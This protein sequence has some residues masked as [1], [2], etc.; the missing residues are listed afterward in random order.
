MFIRVQENQ[1]YLAINETDFHELVEVL[2][3]KRQLA[4]PQTLESRLNNMSHT[5]FILRKKNQVKILAQ[6]C[7]YRGHATFNTCGVHCVQFISIMISTED[8]TLA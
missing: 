1:L 5:F 8:I 3:T 7:M 6:A 4:K 2:F